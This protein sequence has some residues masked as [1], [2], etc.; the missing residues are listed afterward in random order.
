MRTVTPCFFKSRRGMIWANYD[1]IDMLP[2][3]ILML[4][5]PSFNICRLT[6][7]PEFTPS[8]KMLELHDDKG[9]EP[10]KIFAWCVRDAICK[11]SGIPPLDER[12]LLKDR[13]N[14]EELMAGRI[15]EAEING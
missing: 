14:Y 2:L 10:W 8:P 3:Q 13:L 7:M 4:S 11:H 12:L 5:S 1:S 6:I 15:D 9:D